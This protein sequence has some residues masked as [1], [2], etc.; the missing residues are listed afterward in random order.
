MK[1]YLMLLPSDA[2]ADGGPDDQG[3]LE[4]QAPG[5]RWQHHSCPGKTSHEVKQTRPTTKYR[6]K[7]NKECCNPGHVLQLHPPPTL[8]GDQLSAVLKEQ[9]AQHYD[10]HL[11]G[12]N[13]NGKLHLFESYF[14]VSIQSLELAYRKLEQ[15]SLSV[16]DYKRDFKLLCGKIG[17][18]HNEFGYFSALSDKLFFGLKRII[19]LQ[20]F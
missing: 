3:W 7:D 10:E 12:H 13:Y 18:D 4:H 14:P 20:K 19:T 2:H 6:N 8:H 11:P 15:G 5:H 16:V 17:I 1:S 9:H